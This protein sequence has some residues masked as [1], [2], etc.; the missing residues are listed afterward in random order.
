M[1][2]NNDL[3]HSYT[4]L[5][6]ALGRV[7]QDRCPLLLATLSV[8]LLARE[9]DVRVVLDLIAQAERLAQS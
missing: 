2:N 3:D 1:M 5:S 4:E 9:N 8:A 7:G 6:E